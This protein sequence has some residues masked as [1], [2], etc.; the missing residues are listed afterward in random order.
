MTIQEN[1][2]GKRREYRNEHTYTVCIGLSFES[3]CAVNWAKIA[4]R[5]TTLSG[6]RL[7]KERRR[8]PAYWEETTSTSDDAERPLVSTDE[9]TIGP[10]RRRI[11]HVAEKITNGLSRK[12][13]GRFLGRTRD[14]SCSD[15][16]FEMNS[17]GDPCLASNGQLLEIVPPVNC[18]GTY[19]VSKG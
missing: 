14:T 5:R 6:I 11:V 10:Y 19:A 12:Y 9:T 17:V 2:N 7:T 13:I 3:I 8:K 18:A 4:Q 1:A 16:G 15:F